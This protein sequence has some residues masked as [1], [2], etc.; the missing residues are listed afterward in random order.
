MKKQTNDAPAS[1]APKSRRQIIEEAIEKAMLPY[2]RVLPP[3]GLRI[4]REQLED[5][6]MTHPVALDALDAATGPKV[7]DRSG[8]RPRRDDGDQGD[9]DPE[10]TG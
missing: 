10:G 1:E 8:T 7:P 4:M 9:D 3:E 2:L 6:L 5:A